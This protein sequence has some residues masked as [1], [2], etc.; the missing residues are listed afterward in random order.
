MQAQ[1]TEAHTL[2]ARV[3][4]LSEWSLSVGISQRCEI[5]GDSL[6]SDLPRR[7]E[8]LDVSE[9][10]WSSHVKHTG[11]SKCCSESKT[12]RTYAGVKSRKS[13]HSNSRL[14]HFFSEITGRGETRDQG[15][16]DSL[17]W[18]RG[19]TSNAWTVSATSAMRTQ[20]RSGQLSISLM[21]RFYSHRLRRIESLDIR[22]EQS[23]V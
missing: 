8:P 2:I 22:G 21:T 16:W 18:R 19:S 3:I 12:C 5:T 20:M 10:H 11:R 7:I 23:R 1:Q 13:D 9:G 17:H 15:R 6:Y 14:H 4:C